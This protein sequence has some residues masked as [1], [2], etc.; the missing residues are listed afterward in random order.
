MIKYSEEQRQTIIDQYKE[1]GQEA[2]EPLAQLMETSVKSIIAVLARAKVYK[3]QTYTPKYGDTV[4]SK[5][6]LVALIEAASGVT[7]TSFEG[8]EKAPKHVLFKLL[9]LLKSD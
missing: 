9:D 1:K 2:I 3:K 6:E 4:Y 5:E 7:A 8:L